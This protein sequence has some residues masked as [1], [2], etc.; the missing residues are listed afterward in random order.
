MQ[1][2]PLPSRHV[3]HLMLRADSLEETL[4]LGKT[5]GRRRRGRPWM[6]WLD[7]ITK[8]KG[9]EF[10]QTLGDSEGQGSLV[11]C[12]S[13]GHK[14]GHDWATPHQHNTQVLMS[15]HKRQRKCVEDWARQQDSEDLSGELCPPA[16]TT[17]YDAHISALFPG[18]FVLLKFFFLFL[19]SG[20]G[21]IHERKGGRGKEGKR[22]GRE[23]GRK[24]EG[25][26][27]KKELRQH[28][29]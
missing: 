13:R 17:W 26:K 11:C 1:F 19:T 9:H 10:A 14:V 5:E 29:V 15:L 4:M 6:S 25:L 20:K 7:S 27:W 16:T 2:E 12:S 24:E 23:G 18:P 8:F 22:E 28:H 21:N 3:G